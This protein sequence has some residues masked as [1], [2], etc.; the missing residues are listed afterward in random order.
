MT[1]YSGDYIRVYNDNTDT[2]TVNISVN[3]EDQKNVFDNFKKPYWDL[4]NWNY[5]YLRNNIENTNI[6]ASD[7]SR[8]FGNY[9]IIEFTFLNNDGKS[10][11]F[12]NVSYNIVK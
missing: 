10:I 12:Y 6:P 5:S 4:G 1:P 7:M 11:E 2:G 8:I 9:F 3:T